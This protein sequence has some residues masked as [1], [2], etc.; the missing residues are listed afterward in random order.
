VGF[1]EDNALLITVIT[2]VINIATTLVAIATI[3]RLGRKPLLLIGSA[4]MAVCPRDRFG[5][6][7]ESPSGNPDLGSVAGPVALAAANL[8]VVFFGMSW[9]PVVRV[10]LGEMFPN[11]IRAIALSVAAAV[12][13]VANFVVSTTFP[14]L[15]DAG[16]GWPTASTRP[17]RPCRSCSC[18]SS[19]ARRKGRELEEM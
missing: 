5:T 19:C 16:L 7:P 10:V 13:W 12:Q 1:S 14:P 18:G 6:A 3:D 9:G 2:S 17:R 11:R 15:K 4:G 8:F